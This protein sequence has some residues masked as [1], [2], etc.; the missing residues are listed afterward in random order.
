MFVA[1]IEW[2]YH[3]SL[4]DQQ[5]I[6]AI[7]SAARDVGLHLLMSAAGCY[8]NLI[9][10]FV[11]GRTA[12]MVQQFQAS[13]E[14]LY[15]DIIQFLLTYADREA[16]IAQYKCAG[17]KCYVVRHTDVKQFIGDPKPTDLS[18]IGRLSESL[19]SAN[20]GRGHATSVR[21]MSLQ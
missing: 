19:T 3:S 7:F 14:Q 21:K 18:K 6:E 12:N 10:V 17:G 20:K 9:N 2:N 4:T 15:P 8:N 1:T 11:I 13:C 5:A 16:V